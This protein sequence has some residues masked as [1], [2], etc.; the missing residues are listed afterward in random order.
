VEDGDFRVDQMRMFILGEQDAM[1]YYK[2]DINKVGG[3]LFGAGSVYFGFY[4]II[5]PALYSTVVGS[6]SPNMESK[7]FLTLHCF[8]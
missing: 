1:K 4:G 8:M 6:F 5:G 2:N 3:F 7:K